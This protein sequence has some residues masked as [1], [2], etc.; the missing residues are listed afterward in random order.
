MYVVN[1]NILD[2]TVLG[3]K[4]ISISKGYDEVRIQVKR[5]ILFKDTFLN[6]VQ[7]IRILNGRNK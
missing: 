6:I 5:N 2:T 7:T 4:C 1:F 3:D